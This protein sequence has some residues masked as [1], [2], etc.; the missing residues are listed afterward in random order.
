MRVSVTGSLGLGK[1]NLIALDRIN[2]SMTKMNS[3]EEEEE[4][5]EIDIQEDV[6]ETR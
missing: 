2:I 1:S 5:P 6:S 3:T 4:E